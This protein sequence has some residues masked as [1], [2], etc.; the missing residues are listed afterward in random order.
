MIKYER[1]PIPQEYHAA[2]R[3]CPHI[4]LGK[5]ATKPNKS[6][7]LSWNKTGEDHGINTECEWEC[8]VLTKYNRPPVLA[9]YH[10]ANPEC[11]HIPTGA[12]ATMPN[13]NCPISYN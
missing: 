1:P 7:P 11:P 5:D 2:N 9:G 4:P 13:K 3:E 12:D 8:D 10:A 6:C